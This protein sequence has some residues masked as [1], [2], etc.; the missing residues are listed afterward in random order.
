MSEERVFDV[1]E[2]LFKESPSLK[3]SSDDRLVIF[4]DLHMGDGG[5]NDEFKPNAPLF[6]EVLKKYYLEREYRLVLNGDVEELY[7]FKVK[8]VFKA[9]KDIYDI[10]DRFDSRG[11]FYKIIGNHD[12]LASHKS[13]PNANKNLLEGIR[14]Y[15]EDVPVFLYHGHQTANYFE[16]YNPIAKLFVRTFVNAFGIENSSFPIDS[17]KKFRTE[18]YAY[19]FASMKKLIS[20]LGHTH[21]PLFESMSKI[22]SVIMILETLLRKF[23]I[24][25]GE[26]KERIREN[27]KKFKDELDNLYKQNKQYNLRN[28]L[29]N[30]KVLVPCLFNSGSVIGKRGLTGIEINKGNISLVYWFDKNRSRRYIDYKGV[31]L[32]HLGETEIYKAILKK[33][34]LDYIYS[35]IKLLT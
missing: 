19:K 18:V 12:F 11:H 23:P 21:R 5:K 28:G 16:K 4:S 14:I 31:K 26:K 1:L 2:L 34:S 9:W 30:E 3:L 13:F 10:F 15:I 35:R 24:T 25:Q 27:I 29:Y 20:I 7:K 32:K 17:D 8:D 33:E 6:S 22:D